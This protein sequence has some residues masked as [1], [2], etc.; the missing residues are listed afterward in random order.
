M[1]IYTYTLKLKTNTKMKKELNKRLQKGAAIYSETLKELLNRER[2][3]K[4]DP[5]YKQ[6]YKLEKGKERNAILNELDKKY[7]LSK[8]EAIAISSKKR[9][10]LCLEAYIPSKACECLGDRAYL[11]FKKKH[12]VINNTSRVVRPK[13][14]DSLVSPGDTGIRLIN[15][16]VYYGVSIGKWKTHL[17]EI[18]VV[19][20]ND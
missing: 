5:L 14:I 9:K 16:K 4:R 7:K 18:P 6:A 2:K 17:L 13:M 1:Q 15:G 11:A 3:L 10:D 19:Y 12:F 20:K 8:F